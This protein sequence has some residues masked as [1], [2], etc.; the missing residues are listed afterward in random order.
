MWLCNPIDQALVLLRV[1]WPLEDVREASVSLVQ[2]GFWPK[3]DFHR[4]LMLSKSGLAPYVN[5]ALMEPS[6]AWGA[7]SACQ[8]PPFRPL[9]AQGCQRGGQMPLTLPPHIQRCA[10]DCCFFAPLTQ[11]APGLNSHHSRGNIKKPTP[12]THALILRPKEAKTP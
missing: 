7:G 1:H 11:L 6:T 4:W 3:A 12:L 9:A 5:V 2:F 10:Q 8:Y